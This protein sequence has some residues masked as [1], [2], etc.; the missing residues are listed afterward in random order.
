MY[1]GAVAQDGG[2]YETATLSKQRM[3]NVCEKDSV[4]EVSPQK[5]RFIS[6]F[7]RD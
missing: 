3:Y 7:L 6:P 1:I 5:E 4:W 2:L